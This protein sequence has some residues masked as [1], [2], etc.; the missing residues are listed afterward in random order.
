MPV[1]GHLGF[2]NDERCN[3][4]AHSVSKAWYLH[5]GGH[6]AL[7][8]REDEAANREAADPHNVVVL[9]RVRTLPAISDCGGIKRMWPVI[10]VQLD[11]SWLDMQPIR[12]LYEFDGPRA[13]TCQ[14][15]AD[16]LYLSY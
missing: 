1:A 11:T 12:I 16:N 4:P 14:D 13:F 3:S 5:R 9:R 2:S 7:G 15:N 6:A 8:M 10:G